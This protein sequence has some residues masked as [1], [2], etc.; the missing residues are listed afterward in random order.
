[1]LWVYYSS[2][3]LYLGATFAKFYAIEFA[4]PIEASEYAE[5]VKTVEITSDSKT[6]QEEEKEKSDRI[7]YHLSSITNIPFITDVF[8]FVLKFCNN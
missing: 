1:M 3:I 5:I 6:L 2:V 7:I 8:F 4:A